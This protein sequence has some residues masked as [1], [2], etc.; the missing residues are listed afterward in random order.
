MLLEEGV[1]NENFII[2]KYLNF[3]ST[4]SIPASDATRRM[5]DLM[6]KNLSDGTRTYLPDDGHPLEA[7]YSEYAKLASE[8]FIDLRVRE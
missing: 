5:V 6:G 4:L 1:E 8:L 7:G 2:K 3:F